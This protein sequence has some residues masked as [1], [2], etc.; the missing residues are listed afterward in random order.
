[1]KSSDV[2][3]EINPVFAVASQAAHETHSSYCLTGRVKA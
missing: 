2:K 1:M 3:G